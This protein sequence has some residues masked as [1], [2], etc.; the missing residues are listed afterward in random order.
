MAT[1]DRGLSHLVKKAYKDN[2]FS[3]TPHF[4]SKRI[5]V[6]EKAQPCLIIASTLIFNLSRCSGLRLSFR[7]SLEIYALQLLSLK[8]DS[9]I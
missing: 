8:S 5:V 2:H 3:Q 7:R 4:F 1:W 9:W 6:S